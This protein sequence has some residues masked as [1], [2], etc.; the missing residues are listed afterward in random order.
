MSR[1]LT[2]A[3]TAALSAATLMPMEADAAKRVCG[4]RAK[5]TKFLTDKFTEQPR[6]VGVAG[7]GKALVE[8]YTSSEGTWTFLL[9]TAKGKSCII[10]AGHSWEES[11]E[12]AMLPKS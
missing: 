7:T 12:L 6:A 10:G 11:D 8:V 3:T 4:E 1:L 2:L 5:M 9:T